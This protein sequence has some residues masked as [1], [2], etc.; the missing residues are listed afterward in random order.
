M[1]GR[2]GLLQPRSAKCSAADQ[3]SS[4]DRSRA[5]SRTSARTARPRRAAR[6]SARAACGC[7][8][9]IRPSHA[10][11]VEWDAQHRADAC[12]AQLRPALRSSARAAAPRAPTSRPTW[13]GKIAT[14]SASRVGDDGRQIAADMSPVPANAPRLL[15]AAL[16][17]QASVTRSK[18]VSARI[19]RAP[20]SSSAWPLAVRKPGDQP[21]DRAERIRRS[22]RGDGTASRSTRPS[23][24]WK[25]MSK[26]SGSSVS[27]TRIGAADP[28]GPAEPREEVAQVVQRLR[29]G[30]TGRAARRSA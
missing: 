2:E 19:R 4:A 20:P 6:S 1:P 30:R 7:R 16:S 12:A 26:R 15:S 9:G 25:A 27:R 22:R 13:R 5:A 11:G 8:S 23:L 14:G 21:A 18:P 24:S 3:P 28:G 17:P 10:V 29:R